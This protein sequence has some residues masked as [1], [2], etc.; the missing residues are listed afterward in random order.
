M[1][2]YLL[3][4]L[5]LAPTMA[6][7]YGLSRF[8]LRR[9]MLVYTP[10]SLFRESQA[11]VNREF[12]EHSPKY[13]ITDTDDKFQLTVDVPGVTAS[14]INITLE[15]DGQVLAIAGEREESGENYSD[16]SKFYQSFSLD[17]AIE[18]EK[19]TANLKDGVLVV[20]AP[21]DLKRIEA[22]VQHIPIT[23]KEHDVEEAKEEEIKVET[24]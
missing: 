3:A 10:G 1:K 17:P 16:S 9:P 6:S 19:I 20:A 24:K 21:K 23:E 18:T 2:H 12:G 15:N 13:Q 11:L 8:G 5:A 14:N 22:A 7:S 4:A